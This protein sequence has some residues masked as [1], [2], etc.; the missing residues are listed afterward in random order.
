[1]RIFTQ[2]AIA[3]T[4]LLAIAAT[5]IALLLSDLYNESYHDYARRH[6][7]G[8]HQVLAEALAD[9][10]VRGQAL[11]VRAILEEVL[12]GEAGVAYLYVTDFD[13]K[14]F[15][16][17]F[18]YGFP[19]AL[20]PTLGL[21][22]TDVEQ[23][24]YNTHSGGIDH[25]SAPMIDGMRARIYIGVDDSYRR[26]T[27]THLQQ[28]VIGI[29]LAVTAIG[30]V[31]WLLLARRIAA[32]LNRLTGF[33]SRYGEG[34]ALN[35]A[36]LPHSGSAE[37]RQLT[38]AMGDMVR[39]RNE[40]ADSL[41]SSEAY[42]RSLF[43]TLPVG[44]ALTRMDGTFVEVNQAYAAMIGRSVDETLGMSYWEVTPKE[45]MEAEQAQLE[46]LA[47]SGRYGP[48]EK[49]Y[50][51]KAGHRVPV[52]LIGRIIEQGG[53]RFI[54]S[55]VEDISADH[56]IRT[57]NARLRH[58]LENSSDE[59][60]LFNGSTLKFFQVSS[61]ALRNLGYTMDE[62][63]RMTPVDLKPAFTEASFAT[64]IEPLRSGK[65]KQLI[66][67]TRHCRKDG[68]CYPVEVRL[69]YADEQGEPTFFAIILD[70]TER[71]RVEAEL[72]M[73]RRH[74]EKLVEARTSTV[75]QQ[76][77]IIHQT[78]DSIVTT[79]LNG[80]VTSW[81]GGAE[82]L[83]GITAEKALGQ[84][85]SFVYPADQRDHDMLEPLKEQGRLDLEVQMKRTDGSLFPAHLSLSL[86][87]DEQGAPSG[88]IGYSLDMTELK[89]REE[90]LA[91]LTSR[92]QDSNKELESFAYSVS[93]DLRAPLR[94]IDG[95]SLAL[96]EDYADRLDEIGLDYLHR[97]RAGAQRMGTLIDDML[98]LSR[99]ARSE[100]NLIELDLG[101]IARQVIEELS[102]AEPDRDVEFSCGGDMKVRGDARLL[103]ALLDNLLGNAWKFTA[104][105]SVARISFA[106]SIGNPSIFY[107]QDNG[108][109][110]DTR[111]ADKLFGAFQ[112]LHRATDFP[113][114]GVGLA[115]AQRIVR[116]HGG[117]IWADS[118]EGE[119]ATFYFDLGEQ[120]ERP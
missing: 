72:A 2:L 102:A 23:V 3:G 73:H 96:V 22:V 21:G 100:L 116:R 47:Q 46:S 109:G 110:F 113:G 49:E 30:L 44:L 85:I 6:S 37:V 51:H 79:D 14:L 41:E 83:F 27:L 15:A 108:V 120:T 76:A 32:P 5:V 91:L 33:V 95:F 60:Y 40:L 81:N 69:Q 92:L 52:R 26:R 64:L 4:G 16:H 12:S 67:E 1:M 106:R 18:E 58:I 7:L 35:P 62:L 57:L 89:R 119:G 45:F 107:I 53:E 101:E 48:Y 114:T 105:E 115:T 82:Q 54:W 104:H 11:E 90:K 103:R 9:R 66:F 65:T 86:L 87:Y 43:E 10:V 99:L 55:A 94:G 84:H 78:H 13:G 117:R 77:Q 97:I 68:S 111:H 80:I 19:R 36:K 38:Q 20:L 59:I 75:R 70:L 112:R 31:L 61:G 29:A 50:L 28:S 74:L 98:A 63:R 24:H 39:R 118:I 8:L 25:Y 42:Q 17:T 34:T 93:H 88:M 56:E 71:K